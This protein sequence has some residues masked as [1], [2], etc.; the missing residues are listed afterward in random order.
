MTLSEEI[1]DIEQRANA[2]GM[3]KIDLCTRA[4]VSVSSFNRWLAGSNGP[5]R[6]KLIALDDAINDANALI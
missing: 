6:R 1:T 3:T 5:T 2:V 4:G